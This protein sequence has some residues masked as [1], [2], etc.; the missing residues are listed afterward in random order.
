[1]TI[2]L[3]KLQKIL[4][5]SRSLL[6]NKT[7]KFDERG[8]VFLELVIGLPLI[9][10]LILSM[11]HIFVNT[12]KQC[13]YMIA[14]FVLQQEMES[15]MVRII[16][17]A[18][19]AY[20][21]ELQTIPSPTIRFWHHKIDDYVKLEETDETKKNKPWYKSKNGK[22]YRNGESSP[23]T[24]DSFLSETIIT[25]YPDPKLKN[26]VLYISLTGTSEVTRHRIVLVT[27]VFM[28]GCNNE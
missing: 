22:I 17:D 1:M 27:E 12:W 6:I 7:K 16:D 5:L 28:K 25:L 3:K 13:K 9:I 10:M 15:A 21:V 24:G 20:D 19:T 11:N 2:I 14:D 18:K 8:F 4:G 26:N 23:I